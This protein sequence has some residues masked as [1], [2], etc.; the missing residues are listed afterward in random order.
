MATGDVLNTAVSGLLAFQRN[1]AVIGQNI[2]NAS[3]AGYSRQTAQ[4]VTNP[5]QFDGS[6]YIGTGVK[7]STVTRAYDSFVTTQLRTATAASSQLDQYYQLASQV[8]NL[9][10]D[11]NAGLSP[12]L[13]SFFSAVQGVSNDPTSIPARQV[14]L[15]EGG[16]LAARFQYINDRLNAMRDDVNTQISTGVTEINSLASSIAN[17]NKQITTATGAGSGQPAND[18][19]DQRDELIRQLAEKVSVTAVAQDDGSVNVFIGNGQTLVLGQTANSLSVTGNP[20]DATRKEVSFVS[21]GTTTTVSNVIT[22]GSLGAALAFRSEILDSAQNALGQIAIGISSTVN[23]QHAL[24]MDLYGNLG[25]DFFNPIDSTSPT[26]YAHSSNTGSAQIGVTISDVSALTSSDYTLAYDGA[27]YTVTRLSDNATVYSGAALPG[28]IASE[29]LTFSLASGTVNSGDRFLIQPTRTGANDI[30]MALT[31]PAA[32]AAAAPIRTAAANTNSGSGIVSAGSVNTPPPPNANLQQ[33]VTITF[34]SPTT[35][36][37]SGTGTGNPTGVAYVSG[38]DIS[39]NGWTFKIT[40]APA[41][42]DLFTVSANTNG[43]DDNRNALAIAG[44]QT[45]STLGGATASYGDVYSEI[46][47][48]VGTKTHAAQLDSTAQSTLLQQVT[49]QRNSISGVNL[50]EEAANMLRFQQ[51]YQAAAQMVT[52]SGAIFQTLLAAVRG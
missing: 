23:D 10:A 29:G 3:T 7:V 39:Y 21:G 16:S 34:T 37:V 2:S 48:D 12:N 1:L 4:M 17:V 18:L 6:G 31:D 38:Q 24:G 42:G 9:F 33:T 47:A 5:P 35:F 45:A 46:V 25:G 19:L 15:S 20:Y 13:S 30:G 44:L 11:S 26:V 22:G 28:T 8:D 50:D 41:T 36:D 49:D 32:V 52:V 43:Y 14:L 27:T 51:A 40:G